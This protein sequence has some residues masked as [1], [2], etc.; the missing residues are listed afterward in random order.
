[1]TSPPSNNPEADAALPPKRRGRWL[2]ICRRV[3]SIS[4][5][6]SLALLI[7]AFIYLMAGRPVTLPQSVQAEIEDRATKHLA[8]GRLQ[9]D[10]LEF[11]FRDRFYPRIRFN[12]M[13][14]FGPDG[15]R[16]VSFAS[17][18]ARLSL[19][20]LIAGRLRP[21][22]VWITGVS[23]KLQRAA[24]G[25]FNLTAEG[26]A[27]APLRRAASVPD[28]IKQVD[29]LL[30]RRALADLVEA[31][32]QGLTLRYE[33]LRT[34]RGW[35]VDGG[36]VR[37]AREGN[38][39]QMAADLALLSGGTGVAT[40]EAT[41]ETVLGDSAA[42]FGVNFT[43]VS[44]GD[45]AAQGP[46]FAWLDILR[47]PIS[48]ALRSGVSDDGTVQELNATLTIRQG[49][50]QPTDATR[51]IPFNG[52]RSYFTYDPVAQSI[53]FDELSIDS[54]WFAGR[55]EGQAFLNG[56]EAGQLTDLVGQFTISGLQFDPAE[57]YPE[58]VI[59]DGLQMD[60]R[61]TPSPFRF[62]LGQGLLQDKGQSLALSGHLVAAESGWDYGLDAQMD[63]ISAERVLTLW[64]P[65]LVPR[66]RD[67]LSRN[68]LKAHLSDVDVSLR[69]DLAGE[70]QAYLSF[71]YADAD[72][73]YARTLPP[74]TG[75]SGHA[76]L[77]RN[78]FVISVDRGQV[79]PPTGGP[80]SAAGSSFIIPD[81]TVKGGPPG[82]ARIVARGTVTSA[83][84][85]LD[86]P[87]LSVM[88]KANL[89]VDLADGAM[90]VEGALSLPLRRGVTVADLEY[91]ATGRLMNVSSTKLIEGRSLRAAEFGLNVNEDLVA[92][93][94]E[95]T[96]DGVPFQATWSSPIRP[97]PTSSR[98]EG[99]VSLSPIAADRFDLGLP[100]GALQGEA[101]GKLNVTLP[102]GGPP[103]FT[104][105]SDM[106]GLG[107]SIP[108]MGWFKG[109]GS[110]GQ[111][112]VAGTL[113]PTPEVSRLSL[114]AAGLSATGRVTLNEGGGLSRARFDQVSLGDWL[115]G[116]VDLVGRGRGQPPEIVLRGGTLDMRRASFGQSGGGGGSGGAATP[117]RMSLDRLQINDT[118]ALTGVN[119]TFVS[120][121]QGMEGTFTAR[122]NGG[123]EV[124]GQLVPRDGRSALRLTSSDAGGVFAAAG[125]LRQARGGN[126]VLTL[127]PSGE[128]GSFDGT[129]RVSNTRVKDAPAMADLLSAISIVGL[130]EQLSGDGIVFSDV[131]ANFRLT[132]STVILTGASAT[133]PSMGLSMDGTYLVAD[134]ALDM[135][136][137]ISP[138]YFLNGL[139]S[140]FT[141]PGE[142]LIGFNYRMAGPAAEPRVS[143]NP[144]SALT[145]GMFRDLFRA[146][147]PRIDNPPQGGNALVPD[148]RP[149]RQR[150]EFEGR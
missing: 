52:A 36:R 24:D 62:E 113:G 18:E 123:A 96:L 148:Q 146:P 147:P 114:N 135:Q 59:I 40:L 43:D 136:G 150:E 75:A 1:M 41:Y 115:N 44:A 76:N 85:L 119:G 48:G 53:T 25:S 127:L 90:R 23:A 133:G 65:G 95:G 94:G 16:I 38:D 64:P 28:L 67:W 49:V 45:I 88:S 61:L 103:E 47:A 93:G 106:Q 35:T 117:I 55:A 83:L 5:S 98:V 82:V 21:S 32:L 54:K 102:P 110:S 6:L 15:R 42:E 56:L 130:L 30:A 128:S 140:I 101:Q 145:P 39:L 84:S 73:R 74:I 9:F 34:E 17:V 71:D 81:V 99:L 131:T 72:V 86:V 60:F 51:P 92:I 70:P 105:S 107:V 37:M 31:E 50:V 8:G 138:V 13:E 19:E 141:R 137:V 66:T 125:L 57:L 4:I 29:R 79:T 111:L 58:P 91:D 14:I 142:G 77:L 10:Q 68:L 112:E 26:E 80:I 11:V 143:V 78:R 46:A 121:R 122:V 132:P 22:H 124:T 108:Q 149:R 139:G 129:L 63:G 104:L 144:L 100:N 87:P 120:R 134:K 126:L 7:G 33:D 116:P 20:R 27:A 97:G 89:P 118:I 69:S 3:A 12:D 2:R 109:R